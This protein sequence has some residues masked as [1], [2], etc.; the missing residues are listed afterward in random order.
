MS[1]RDNI[2]VTGSR[3]EYISFLNGIF[4]RCNFEPF[5]CSLK[6]TDRV[7]FSHQHAGSVRAHGGVGTT[8]TYVTISGNDY[9][10][11][12]NHYV[13]CTFDTVGQRL[14]AA[15]QVIEFG[16]CYR[17]V[18][19]DSRNQQFAFLHHLV[20][21]V[22]TGSRFFRNTLHFSYRTMPALVIFFQDT[23]QC[24]QNN[25]FFMVSTFT[26]DRLS[27]VFSAISHVNKQ[28]SIASVVN[29]HLRAFSVRET[30]CH[31]G[32]PPVFFQC[33]TFPG[34]NRNTCCSNSCGGMI[35]CREDVT[36][37]P[38]YIRSQRN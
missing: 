29:N 5:H 9:H 6:C 17:V 10:F 18:H 30:E 11:T 2:T 26:V 37:C 14:A 19:I 32:T 21:T 16:F 24:I 27:I 38:A 31:I 25:L 34:K 23:V 35:L 36:A 22:N 7:D 1:D 15:I 33:F 13:G 8:F 20:Q 12:C 3:N 4:H 28:R